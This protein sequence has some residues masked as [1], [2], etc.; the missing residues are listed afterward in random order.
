MM[1]ILI[2]RYNIGSEA[3]A[4]A[5]FKEFVANLFAAFWFGNLVTL[6]RFLQVVVWKR[7]KEINEPLADWVISISVVLISQTLGWLCNPEYKLFVAL[8]I[9]FQGPVEAPMAS[10]Y[11][12][13]DP[14]HQKFS[15]RAHVSIG[16]PVKITVTL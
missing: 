6:L 9:F 12:D 10:C 4:T 8:A 2:P 14:F 1:N 16:E 5:F 13:V 7:V 11:D 15:I 3:V